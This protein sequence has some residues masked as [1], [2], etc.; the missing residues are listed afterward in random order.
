[1]YLSVDAVLAKLEG[2]FSVE[3]IPILLTAY[4]LHQSN[5]VVSNIFLLCDLLNSSN[6]CVF[7][8][9]HN[10][11]PV[12]FEIESSWRIVFYYTKLKVEK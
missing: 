5:E 11:K 6:F 10:S 12:Y 2:Y 8:F 7:N 3:P 4:E 1:M 9:C